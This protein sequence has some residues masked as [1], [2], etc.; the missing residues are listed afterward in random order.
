MIQLCQNAD[1]YSSTYEELH[2]KLFPEQKEGIG[3]VWE[4]I[5]MMYQDYEGGDFLKINTTQL[6]NFKSLS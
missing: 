4:Y 5:N 1:N 6:D 2:S 3:L